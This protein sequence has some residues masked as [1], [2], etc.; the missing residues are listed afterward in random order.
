M[1][2]KIAPK[3]GVEMNG[4]HQLLVCSD[5]DSILCEEISTAKRPKKL[6]EVSEGGLKV[7]AEKKS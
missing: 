2:S 4:A 1:A 6:L 3:L 7:N 5:D